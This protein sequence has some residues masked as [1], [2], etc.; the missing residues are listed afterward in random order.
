MSSNSSYEYPPN[1]GNFP[2][3]SVSRRN[4]QQS[5]SSS[6]NLLQQS[7]P[8]T[9]HDLL[10]SQYLYHDQQRSLGQHEACRQGK[11]HQCSSG[12]RPFQ[13]ANY[14]CCHSEHQH[15]Q[16]LSSSPVMG[17]DCACCPSGSHSY[18]P[19]SSHHHDHQVYEQSGQC[20]TCA[21]NVDFRGY[22]V[23][24]IAPNGAIIPTSNICPGALMSAG[25]C[26]TSTALPASSVN[27]DRH[28]QYSNEGLHQMNHSVSCQLLAN[29]SNSSASDIFMSKSPYKGSKRPPSSTPPDN[30]DFPTLPCQIVS[31]VQIFFYFSL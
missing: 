7:A 10:G 30:Y 27:L 4:S 2:D 14:Q 21:N 12:H 31:Y 11:Q 8:N 5:S 25:N 24:L 16:K 26:T 29:S 19:A 15:A 17:P 20:S 22:S 23:A 28:L 3:I 18:L 1:E 9:Q 13:H 6:G